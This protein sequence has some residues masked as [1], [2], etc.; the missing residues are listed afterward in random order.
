MGD[1]L[2]AECNHVRI[3]YIKAKAEF[4]KKDDGY[5]HGFIERTN[6]DSGLTRIE[7]QASLV[8]RGLVN[9]YYSWSLHIPGDQ[10][11][12]REFQIFEDKKNGNTK[13]VLWAGG[14]AFEDCKWT[15]VN[16]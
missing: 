3:T 16:I 6:D 7:G 11:G 15:G 14:L 9:S 5:Y 12:E 1:I 2:T 10:I 4:K 13:V 8:H